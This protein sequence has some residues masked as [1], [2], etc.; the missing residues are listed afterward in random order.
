MVCTEDHECLSN[1][2]T[3][4]FC[5]DVAC[6]GECEA[7]AAA[8]SGGTDGVC[9]FI[10][11]GN[12]PE[13][14]CGVG[15]HCNGAGVCL[16]GDGEPC[17][18]GGEC[19]SGNCA[20]DVCCTTACNGPCESCVLLY[21]GVADGA[22][23]PVVAYEDPDGECAL[24]SSCDGANTCKK[25]DG[26]LCGGAGE[27]ITGQ[28]VDGVCCDQICGGTCRSCLGA[29]TGGLDGDCAYASFGL[30]PDTECGAGLRCDG[31]GVFKNLDGQGG[32]DDS[33]CLSDNCAY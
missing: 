4:G 23:A 12:D 1:E 29:D 27:C 32:G 24:G 8:L 11:T 3:D 6:A 17:A 10:P 25:N 7:C 13:N 22:C 28:C 14:E 5:C 20:D 18:A 19:L 2:C 15:S 16:G 30:D 26:Q 21:T 33:K 31:S 9:S